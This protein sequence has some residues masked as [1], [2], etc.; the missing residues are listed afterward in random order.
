MNELN[1]CPFC[2]AQAQYYREMTLH[3]VICTN[4]ICPAHETIGFEAPEQAIEAWNN[5]P[6]D[7]ALQHDI[8]LSRKEMIG[9]HFLMIA[10]YFVII[11]TGIWLVSCGLVLAD[12]TTD[13]MPLWVAA[14]F[15]L[16]ATAI[17]YWRWRRWFIAHQERNQ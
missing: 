10:M 11:T 13:F 7:T 14:L 16:P 12:L 17:W 6:D 2:G 4:A 8:S 3:K 15:G 1:P 5:R 9:F